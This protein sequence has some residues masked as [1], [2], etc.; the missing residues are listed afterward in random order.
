MVL[1]T[2]SG[3]VVAIEGVVVT[4]VVDGELIAAVEL[5]VDVDEVELEA[6]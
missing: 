3:V 1:C 4:G 2:T 6:D 5:V